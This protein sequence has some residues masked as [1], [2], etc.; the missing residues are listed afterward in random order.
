MTSPDAVLRILDQHAQAQPRIG[1]I[2]A[3]AGGSVSVSFGAG[4]VVAGMQY[5]T[6]YVP[7]VGDQ[8][9]VVPTSSAW[10]VT[11]K[12]TARPRVVPDEELSVFASTMWFLQRNVN[13][14]S[15]AWQR[16]AATPDPSTG[17]P[18]GW[19]QGRQIFAAGQVGVPTPQQMFDVATVGYY[20]SL[21]ALVPSGSTITGVSLVVQRDTTGAPQPPLA[22][23]VLYGHA[24]TPG[25]PPPVSAPSFPLGFGPYRYP[26][27]AVGETTRLQ[28]PAALVTA[29]LAG[30]VTGLA[31]W[32]DVP[33]DAFVTR[34]VPP[35]D[36]LITYTPPS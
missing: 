5:S 3:I 31:W 6:A 19:S 21:A 9:L 10:V 24:Y 23:P 12:V 30:T 17:V 22:N 15:T 14:G 1:V 36:L 25:S 13:F 34:P 27:V 33:A 35:G 2:A 29:W 8:V 7:A 28:L 32:S 18:G 16:F 11:G 4:A 20:G 26:P